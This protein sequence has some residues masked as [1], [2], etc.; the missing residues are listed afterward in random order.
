LDVAILNFALNLEYLEA[1]YYLRATTGQGIKWNG[2]G[3]IGVG[4]EGGPVTVKSNPRVPFAID[5]VREVAAEIAQDELNHVKFLQ[6]ALAPNAVA[7]PAINLEQSFNTL[8]FDAGLGDRFDPFANGINF[9]IGA[10]IFEDVG[11]TAYHGAAPLITSKDYLG[12][13]AGILAV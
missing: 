8:A 5:F 1:E 13:A 11:V 12:A 7:E 3:V 4:G 9:L 2:G 6:A 10:F